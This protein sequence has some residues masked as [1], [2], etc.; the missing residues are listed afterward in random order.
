AR[1]VAVL[2][3]VIGLT[4]KMS[5]ELHSTVL[6]LENLKQVTDDMNAGI[7]NLDDFLRPLKNYFYWEPH[8]FDIPICWSLRSIFDAMD[9]VD[10]LDDSLQVMVENMDELDSIMPKLLVQ[11]PKMIAI[12]K[13]MRVSTLTMHTTM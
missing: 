1:S 11:F 6:T 13:T 8:C 12:M 7:S 2:Q 9:G 4:Q 3:Q 5:D 10:K